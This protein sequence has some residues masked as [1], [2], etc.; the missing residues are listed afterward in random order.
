[1]RNPVIREIVRTT[2]TTISGGR[3]LETWNDL[4]YSFPG[5][6]GV[7][8]GH[9]S[10]AGW[11]QV[12]AARGPG[13]V[14]YATL[15]GEPT[16]ARRN[17]DLTRLLAWGISR[18]RQMPIVTQG[19]TYASVTLPYDK[20]RLALVAARD[21]VRVLRLGKKLVEEVV[22]PGSVTL[23]VE[24]GD[25]LGRV[26]VYREG[27]LIASSPLVASRAVAAPGLLGRVG[28]YAGETAENVWD[29]VS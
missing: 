20:G 15:L 14:V 29:F 8:T 12:A 7:K 10:G 2:E 26:R 22:A 13:F 3:R 24:K 25:T 27:R 18:F 11:S 1:M 17:E 6:L 21:Q 16:R 9:T 19:R 4:L 23:P 5:L 28:W